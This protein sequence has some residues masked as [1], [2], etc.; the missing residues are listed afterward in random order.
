MMNAVSKLPEDLKSK[1]LGVVLFGY[2]KN[3]QQK[4]GIPNYP[5]EKVKVFCSA[6]DGVCGGQLAVTAGHFSYMGDG[7]GPKA[8]EFLMSVINGAG[9]SGDSGASEPAPAAESSGEAASET[10]APATSPKGGRSG[11]PKGA[12]GAKGSGGST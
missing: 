7:S 11:R 3:G 4:G 5:K 9:K 8:V 10:P 1:V 2:T 12:K 6:S